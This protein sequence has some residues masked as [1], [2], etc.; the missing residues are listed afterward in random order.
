MTFNKIYVEPTSGTYIAFGNR[1]DE[2]NDSNNL[3]I[4]NNKTFY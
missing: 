2:E 3:N 1:A 4:K